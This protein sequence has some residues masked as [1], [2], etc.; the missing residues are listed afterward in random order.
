IRR[1]RSPLS[2]ILD[3]ACS[4]PIKDGVPIA[5][6]FEIRN[7]DRAIGARLAG[8]IARRYGDAGLADATIDLRFVGSAGQSFGAFN[9]AG[10]RMTLTGDANDYVG[11]GMA[12]GEIVIHPSSES[13]FDWSKNVIIGNTVMY[14][15]TGGT[16]FVAGRAGERFCVRNSGGSAVVEGVGDHGCEYMTAGVVVVLGETGRN[17]AAG[18]TGGAAFVFDELGTF[19]SKCNQELVELAR[20]GDHDSQM[21]RGLIE[22]HHEFTGSPRA[23]E[24]LSDWERAR[25][26]F[27]H[28]VTQAETERQKQNSIPHVNVSAAYETSSPSF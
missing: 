5:E 4:E 18:M 2:K 13:N 8:A 24:I 26:L 15:A 11:K 9:V 7:T 3:E 16:L 17:F 28:V 14:G 6:D 19:G 21:V 1:E 12:G 20:I 25:N 23:A 27:W 10:L 22:R